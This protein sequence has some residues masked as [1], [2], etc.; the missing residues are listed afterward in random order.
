M[1]TKVQTFAEARSLVERAYGVSTEPY[2]AEDALAFRVF[3]EP[4]RITGTATLVSKSSGRIREVFVPSAFD[5]LESM[6][7]LGDWPA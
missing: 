5:R 2:G 1:S 3:H 6:K 4:E 7:R